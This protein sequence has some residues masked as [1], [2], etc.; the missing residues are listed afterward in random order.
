MEVDYLPWPCGSHLP[1]WPMRT[2]KQFPAWKNRPWLWSKPQ[3]RRN[4]RCHT[5]KRYVSIHVLLFWGVFCNE[6]QY[7][8]LEFE[9]NLRSIGWYALV[10]HQLKCCF[11]LPYVQNLQVHLRSTQGPIE[12]FLCSDNPIPMEATD[13]S[14]ANDSHSYLSINGNNSVSSLFPYSSLLQACSKGESCY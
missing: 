9:L 7:Y 10:Q 11:L 3:Q 6:T 14:A 4:W 2:F 5:Q 13:G 1:I 12:V 8:E